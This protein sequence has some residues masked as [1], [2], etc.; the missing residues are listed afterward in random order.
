MGSGA[1]DADDAAAH[2]A[3]HVRLPG[4]TDG[5][6]GHGHVHSHAVLPDDDNDD[7]SLPAGWRHSLPLRR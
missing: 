5:D 4:S 7:H 2:G 1:T 6:G 3:D